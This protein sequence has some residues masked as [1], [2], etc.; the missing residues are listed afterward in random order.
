MSTIDLEHASAEELKAE[1]AR[2]NRPT[3]LFVKEGSEYYDP[4]SYN[5]LLAYF[6]DTGGAPTDFTPLEFNQD[7]SAIAARPPYVVINIAAYTSNL[8]RSM[9][10]GELRI[11]FD[12][13]AVDEAQNSDV[14]VP[15]VPQYIVTAAGDGFHVEKSTVNREDFMR[16]Y[17][18]QLSMSDALRILR[19]IED[20]D[21]SAGTA[22]LPTAKATK[23]RGRAKADSAIE[24]GA[25]A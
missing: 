6:H 7:G 13:R 4:E 12:S 21:L 22:K 15:M 9:P 14:S 11:V 18:D 3:P 1:L 8:V 16:Y 17:T 5:R 24:L 2:R 19:V 10:D 25:S 23:G 20:L